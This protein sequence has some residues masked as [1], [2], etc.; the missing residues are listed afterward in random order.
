MSG[1]HSALHTYKEARQKN[2]ENWREQPGR[3]E[4]ILLIPTWVLKINNDFI[5]VKKNND[6]ILILLCQELW[7][8]ED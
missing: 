1:V 2:I 8:T 5:F 3:K 4:W 7:W 6:F